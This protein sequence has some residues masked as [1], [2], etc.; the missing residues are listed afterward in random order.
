MVSGMEIKT[1]M[2]YTN[3]ERLEFA[4]S[5]QWKE[6]D[7][8]ISEISYIH[9]TAVIGRSGFGYV[10]NEGGGLERMP[11]AGNVVIG[12]GVNIGAHTCVDRAVIGSTVI[13]EGSKLDNLIHIGHGAKIGKYCL[14]VAGAVIGGSAEIGDRCY[15]GMG[16]LIK[17][18]VKIG[19]DVTVGMGAV[20]LKD[21]PD[22]ETWIGNPARKLEKK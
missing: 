2:K 6:C 9:P 17:N 22:G 21:I 12:D 7:N 14:I 11:H 10:R 5:H 4:R 3:E 1:I 8:V 16:C 13:G 18:K 15:L 20:V 19:N